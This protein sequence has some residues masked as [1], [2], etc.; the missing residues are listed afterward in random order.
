MPT[1]VGNSLHGFFV[2]RNREIMSCSVADTK[3]Y[4]LLQAQ[5]LASSGVVIGV[6][7]RSDALSTLLI[8]HRLL[9][10]PL[11]ELLEVEALLGMCSP[12]ADV[13]GGFGAIAGDW[14]VIRGRNYGF[15][16]GPDVLLL[17]IFADLGAEHTVKLDFILWTMREQF[18]GSTKYG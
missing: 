13:K 1:R 5:L 9:I 6:Q 15:A 18:A 2:L 16:V 14:H 17:S 3:K 8:R 12:Q 4:W 7:N 10:L 11:V